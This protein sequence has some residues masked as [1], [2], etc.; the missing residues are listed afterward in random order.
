MLWQLADLA[1]VTVRA[2]WVSVVQDAVGGWGHENR[3]VCRHHGTHSSSIHRRR[4]TTSSSNVT[5]TG[6]R[7]SPGYQDFDQLVNIMK[8][9]SSWTPSRSW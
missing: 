6:P 2:Y 4:D 1:R 9:V 7:S 5:I 8:S 3:A